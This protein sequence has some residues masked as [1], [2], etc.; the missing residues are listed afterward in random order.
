[1]N[2]GKNRVIGGG[3]FHHVAIRVK[4]FE[5]VVKFYCDVLGFTQRIAWGE[6][7]KR[8]TML[9]G[10]DGNY[11]EVF[12]GGTDALAKG[13]GAIIHVCF[14]TDDVVAATETVRAAG[15]EVTMEPREIAIG[16]GAEK[17]PVKISFFRGPGGEI[18]EFF[19]NAV[20]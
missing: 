5:K 6:G 17:V 12:A 4:D 10:G 9:D 7:D 18:V 15:M 16:A 19:Q 8:G 11:L 20:L 1:M 3:G 13:E 14:R 2:V